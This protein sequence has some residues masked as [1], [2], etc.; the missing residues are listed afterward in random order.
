M[1]MNMEDKARTLNY[2]AQAAPVND[3]QLEEAVVEERLSV[4][5]PYKLM[6]WRLRRHKLAL[7]SGVIIIILY[8]IAIF[9]E[10]VAPYDPSTRISDLQLAP[11]QGIHF[12]DKDGN[13][14][15]RPFVYGY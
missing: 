7:V 14:S 9:C 6:W 5:S 15:L 8:L 1:K 3:A 11:P 12:V 4:A 10:F 13:F 2:V